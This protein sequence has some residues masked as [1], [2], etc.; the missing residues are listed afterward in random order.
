ME[1]QPSISFETEDDDISPYARYGMWEPT[2]HTKLSRITRMV[3]NYK[4]TPPPEVETHVVIVC[5]DADGNEER[6][7]TSEECDIFDLAKIPNPIVRVE[8]SCDVVR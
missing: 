3:I 8:I 7:T 2:G 5:M 4:S 1:Y 6:I